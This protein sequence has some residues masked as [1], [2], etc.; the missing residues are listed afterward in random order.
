MKKLTSAVEA[1]LALLL[2]VM[3][4]LVFGNVVLRY[5]FNSGIT[6]SEELARF[7]FVW[8]TFIGA[9]LAMQQNA[10]L[11]VDSLIQRLSDPMKKLA[12][13]ISSVLMLICCA[14]FLKGSI[15][16]TIINWSVSAPVTG[17]SMATL[18][19]IGIFTSIGMGVLIAKKLFLLLTGKLAI[20]DLRQVIDS[21]EVAHK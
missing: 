10:H 17:I 8:L 12:F 2:A 7:M 20:E 16:Q 11:G 13:V 5:G 3:A 21:E 1:V 14:V 18:Y 19:G 15:A 6:V 9:V 4:V